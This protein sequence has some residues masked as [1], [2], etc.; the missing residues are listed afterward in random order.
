MDFITSLFKLLFAFAL[1]IFLLEL[2]RDASGVS[3]VLN[4]FWT[5]VGHGYSLEEQA[6]GGQ[7]KAAKK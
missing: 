1:F 2:V 3:T 7:Y 6:G 5:G 4:S